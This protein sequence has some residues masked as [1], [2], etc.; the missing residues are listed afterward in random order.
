M[1]LSVSFSI[2]QFFLVLKVYQLRCLK[3]I[4]LLLLTTFFESIGLALIPSALSIITTENGISRFPKFLKPYLANLSSQEIGFVSLITIIIMFLL[5]HFFNIFSIGYSR[6]FCGFLRDGWRADILKK[7]LDSDTQQIRSQRSGKL[8]DNLITQPSKSAKFIRIFIDALKNLIISAAMIILLIFTSWKLTLLIGFI[9]FAL[10]LTGSIPL[11]RI[12]TSLG[13]KDIK[14]SQQITSKVS[15]TINGILQIKIFN[16]E[17]KWHKQIIEDSRKQTSINVK[18]SIL[19]EIPT[20]LGAFAVVLILISAIFFSS[21]NTVFDLPLIAMFLLVSQRLQNSFGNLMKNYTN[22]RNMKPSFDLVQKLS[23]TNNLKSDNKIKFESGENFDYLELKNVSFSYPNK[24]NILENIS[25]KIQKGDKL[26]IK[27]NSGTGKSTLINLI[28]GLIEPNKGEILINKKLIYNLNNK[29]L[30]KRISYV[31]QDN[32]LFNDT[33]E[34]N[35][36]IFDASITNSEMINACKKAAAHE[37]ITN[38]SNGYN[39]KVGERGLSLSGGQIQRIALARAFLKD[40]EIMIFDEAT[41]ALD[42]KNQE[43]ILNSINYFSQKNKIIIF[44]SHIPQSIIKF[45]KEI[46]LK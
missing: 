6:R 37:F 33:I 35:L 28:C 43:L 15:E 25:I 24:N 18:A 31:S 27:G 11:K 36:K 26:L 2:K 39:T 10:G 29:D 9:F 7:Y 22:L 17:K 30:L 1:F 12:S 3:L 40:G 21:K 42:K 16:L 46:I 44:I 23:K 4:S 5:K 38:L 19:A 8:L 34:N 20:L 14:L 13:R 41:S 32:Y 45:N